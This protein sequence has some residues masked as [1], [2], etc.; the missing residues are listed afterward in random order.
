MFIPRWSPHTWI[1][2]LLHSSFLNL[3]MGKNVVIDEID[4]VVNTMALVIISRQSF[5]NRLLG[6]TT[7]SQYN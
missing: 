3:I 7:F 5:K 6:L 2:R 4:E 1:K